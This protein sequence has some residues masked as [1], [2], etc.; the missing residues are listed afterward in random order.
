MNAKKQDSTIANL[1][2]VNQKKTRVEKIVIRDSIIKR[3]DSRPEDRKIIRLYE[4]S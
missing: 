4:K 1:E 3:R 2:S